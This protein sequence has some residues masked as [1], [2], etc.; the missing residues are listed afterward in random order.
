MGSKKNLKK[1]MSDPQEMRIDEIINL[2]GYY[3]F[4]LAR[5]RGSHYIITSKDKKFTLPVHNKKVKKP[6][7]R[8]IKLYLVDYAQKKA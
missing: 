4:H 2:L 8:D 3:G 7:L 5:V 1:L 6:Y